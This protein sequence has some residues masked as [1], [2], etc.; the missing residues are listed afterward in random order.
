MMKQWKTPGNKV[1][2]RRKAMS[3][4]RKIRLA[5]IMRAIHSA[6][7]IPRKVYIFE[8]EIQILIVN[9]LDSYTLVYRI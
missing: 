2:H 7:V 8:R 4:R 1:Y 5:G 6:G 3:E 9:G